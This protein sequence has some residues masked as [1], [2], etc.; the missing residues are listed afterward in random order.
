[1]TR[2]WKKV[3]KCFR[4]ILSS[5]RENKKKRRI[6][7]ARKKEKSTVGEEEGGEAGAPPSF[8]N[9]SDKEGSKQSLVGS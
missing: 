4:Y 8:P 1:M 5:C 7:N 3:R 2:G 6:K 9:G